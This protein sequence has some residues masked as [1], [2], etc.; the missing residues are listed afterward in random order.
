MSILLFRSFM[1]F[2]LIVFTFLSIEVLKST[3]EVVNRE[4]LV[5]LLI[6]LLIVLHLELR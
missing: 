3:S 6:G 2:V 1:S 5:I 4:S